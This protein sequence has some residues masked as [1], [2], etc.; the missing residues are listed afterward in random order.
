MRSGLDA[1]VAVGPEEV[2]DGLL[3]ADEE[4]PKKSNPRSE[5]P[6]LFCFG[7][8]VG[9]GGSGAVCV[10]GISVVFGLTG[11]AGASSSNKLIDCL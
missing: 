11:G 3:V 8:A 4:V 6:G 7:G 5:S 1:L 9:F 2:L 10:L